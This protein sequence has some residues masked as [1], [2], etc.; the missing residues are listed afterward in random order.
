M[1]ETQIRLSKYDLTEEDLPALIRLW[2]DPRVREFL[3]G[4]AT[5]DRANT[6]ATEIIN[7]S[8]EFFPGENPLRVAMSI[9]DGG[10]LIGLITFSPHHDS[11]EVEVSYLLLPEYWGNGLMKKF[12]LVALEEYWRDIKAFS[13]LAET[14]TGNRRSCRLLE[15]L[16][17]VF[18]RR[19]E[20]FGAEQTIYRF[21]LDSYMRCS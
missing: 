19:V 12:L 17:F 13:V 21:D 15:G 5:L 8:S 20:R 4:P 11:L 2:T 16:G 6:I 1:D 7:S 9:R 10:Q 3:G 18:D 14:Q